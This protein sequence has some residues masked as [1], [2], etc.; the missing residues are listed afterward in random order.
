MLANQE[1]IQ[2]RTSPL[3]FAKWALHLT[4][5]LSGFPTYSAVG[6]FGFVSM[7]KHGVTGKL[8][9]LKGVAKGHLVATNMTKGAL[10]EKNILMIC[11]SPHII[12]LY[13][14]YNA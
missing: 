11:D 10:Q 3:G 8:Y 1:S 9:A 4:I 14:T 13:N 7:E 2:P 12:N 5:T 6:G